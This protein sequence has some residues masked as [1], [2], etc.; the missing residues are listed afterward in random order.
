MIPT[1]IIVS[2]PRY[3]TVFIFSPYKTLQVSG[4]YQLFYLILQ[5]L[6]FVCCMSIIVVIF[7]MFGHVGIG[8][9]EGLAQ[10]GY[11]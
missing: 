5:G 3:G 8:R 11:V 1:I 7:A 6:T 4:A 9:I 2:V 10:Q